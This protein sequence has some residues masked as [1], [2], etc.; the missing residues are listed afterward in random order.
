MDTFMKRFASDSQDGQTELRELEREWQDR[1]FY[2]FERRDGM[3]WEEY[4]EKK[5]P[6]HTYDG[7]NDE[8]EREYGVEQERH[9]AYMKRRIREE[10]AKTDS[11]DWANWSKKVGEPGVAWHEPPLEELTFGPLED[12][13]GVEQ[14]PEASNDEIAEFEQSIVDKYVSGGHYNDVVPGMQYIEMM[15]FMLADK[16]GVEAHLFGQIYKYLFRAGKKDDYE[17]DLR[18][19]RWYMQ[20]LVRYVQTG[21]VSAENN[22]S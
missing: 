11:E 10:E 2:S 12:I 22:D 19:A 18:K 13:L 3:T 5:M 4:K 6:K 14:S 17:Q 9:E 21:V 8:G 1:Y 7:L 15:Q 20:C 16:S